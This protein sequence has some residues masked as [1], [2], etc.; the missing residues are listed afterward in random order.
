MG[1]QE[2]AWLAHELANELARRL[3]PTDCWSGST[4]TI[5]MRKVLLSIGVLGMLCTIATAGFKVPRYVHED[6]EEAQKEAIEEGR[7]LVYIY[8]DPSS[9]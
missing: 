6:L 3:F 4:E 9:S 2:L 8:T 1:R 7:P 5:A